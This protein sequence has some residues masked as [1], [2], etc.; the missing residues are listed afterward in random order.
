MAGLCGF[1]IF[2]LFLPKG[3]GLLTWPLTGYILVLRR[4]Q[5]HRGVHSLMDIPHRWTA[6]EALDQLEEDEECGSILIYIIP[7]LL[8][9][10]VAAE[11]HG[12]VAGEELSKHCLKTHA[13]CLKDV[14]CV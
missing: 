10:Y 14:Y 3:Y 6:A 9:L 11:D 8:P 4:L 5:H 2:V 7:Y 1:S 13:R 12:A